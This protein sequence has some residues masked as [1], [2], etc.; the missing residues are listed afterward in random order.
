MSFHM[1][2]RSVLIGALFAMI[3]ASSPAPAADTLKIAAISRTFFYLPL[4]IAVRQG[5]RRRR[6]RR[7]G[8]ILDNPTRNAFAAQRRGEDRR[9]SPE[10]SIIDF[11]AAAIC[12]IAGGISKLPH[13]SSRSRASRPGRFARANFAVLAEKEG[14][15]PSSRTLPRPPVLGRMTTSSR[16]SAVRPRAGACSRKARST[17]ACSRSPTAT[18]RRTPVS[19]TSARR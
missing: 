18:R 9:C 12:A 13:F 16:S 14:Q 8:R 2:R 3:G 4:W 5:L 11:T 15:P 1:I 7:T 19:A 10:A 6:P 17:P